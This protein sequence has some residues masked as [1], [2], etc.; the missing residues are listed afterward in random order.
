MIP[1]KLF[2]DRVDGGLQLA[3]RLRSYCR[4]SPVIVALARGGVPVA[5][6]VAKA[7]GTQLS[8]CFV[9]KVG[10]PTRPELGIGAVAED[11]PVYIDDRTV[12]LLGISD[13]E[14]ASLVARKRLEVEERVRTFRRGTPP[15]DLRGRTVIVID[16]GIATGV[17]ARAAL[18][19]LRA[20]GATRIALAAPVGA[21]DSLEEL[22]LLVDEVVCLRTAEA[23]YTVDPWYED[24]RPTTDDDVVELFERARA[25][26]ER[27]ERRVSE[28]VR[29]RVD[30]YMPRGGKASRDCP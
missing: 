4:S 14:L 3:A 18:Q 13:E 23:L 24:F 7:F 26:H 17:S 21:L 29:T 30:E 28:R 20:R 5:Y 11:G 19:T 8:V 9:G 2:R 22:E 12:K 16:D 1:R 27:C 6:E 10:A 25:Q 15:L